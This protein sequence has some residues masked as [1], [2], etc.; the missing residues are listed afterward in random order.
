MDESRLSEIEAIEVIR[1]MLG[2]DA[3]GVE[4]GVG[5]DAA[6]FHFSTGGVILTVDGLY[7]G[8]HFSL[9]NFTLSDVGWKAMAVSVSDIAA[10]GGQPAC[11]LLSVAL[12]EP[13][14]EEEIC[15]LI[16][17][18][19]EMAGSCNCQIIGGDLCRSTSGLSLSVTV[20]GT[21]HPCGP[22]LRSCAQVGDI[23][24]VTGT[25]GDSAGG[26][27]VL[28]SGRDDLRLKF[29]GLVEKH[30]R[31]RPA[32]AAG[33]RLASSGVSAMADVSDG[34]AADV[35]HICRASG[36]GCEMVGEEVPLSGELRVLAEESCTDPL[37]WAL[38][39]GEDY[40]LIFTA[41]PGGFEA[42]LAALTSRDIPA[43]RIG[44][45]KP[46]ERGRKLIARDGSEIDLEGLGYD[47]FL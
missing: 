22:V 31:P 3:P 32:V 9:D 34:L 39:G 6:V 38:A 37:Q 27:Y 24:G 23:I 7:E 12:A 29:P 16:G 30:L 21:R 45:I 36:V 13:P 10:M 35:V 2:S 17:G 28:Q 47:H 11:A 46:V 26:L 44:T 41:P 33:D 8:V 20:A 14:T 15:A 18:A 19:L 4:V 42:A 1:G 40:E 43:A 25:L 5:D